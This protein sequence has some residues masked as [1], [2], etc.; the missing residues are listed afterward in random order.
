[1][2]R[3]ALCVCVYVRP[4]WL[5]I[6]QKLF[7]FLIVFVPLFF[8]NKTYFL[9]IAY[10]FLFSFLCL[11]QRH[12]APVRGCGKSDDNVVVKLF[13]DGPEA[14]LRTQTSLIFYSHHFT[15]VYL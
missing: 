14:P 13:S 12:K 9:V 5:I 6:F 3:D 2:K 10:D 4:R 1:M 8:K 7:N 15:K 11:I